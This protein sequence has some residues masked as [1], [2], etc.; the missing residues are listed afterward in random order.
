MKLYYA[1]PI[2]VSELEL[3]EIPDNEQRPQSDE[4][5]T[6]ECS[7]SSLPMVSINFNVKEGK[8]SHITV[9]NAKQHLFTEESTQSQEQTS[10]FTTV[11]KIS[12]F[13]SRLPGTSSLEEKST[14]KNVK[15]TRDIRKSPSNFKRKESSKVFKKYPS[16][17]KSPENETWDKECRQ[18]IVDLAENLSERLLAEIDRYK[19]RNVNIEKD[20]DTHRELDHHV[21]PYLTKLSEELSH[22]SKLTKELSADLDVAGSPTDGSSND[23]LVTKGID[24]ST[25]TCDV[26]N[27]RKPEAIQQQPKM[28]EHDEHD[29]SLSNLIVKDDRIISGLISSSDPSTDAESPGSISGWLDSRR[30][31]IESGYSRTA[32][33]DKSEDDNR[34]SISNIHYE[35]ASKLNSS[36]TRSHARLSIES[37]DMTDVSE[38]AVSVSSEDSM[39][40]REAMQTETSSGLSVESDF[41]DLD[42]S[43]D[44][45]KSTEY[46]SAAGGPASSTKQYAASMNYSV[47]QASL[48]RPG[49]SVES[50]EAGDFS[51]RT[52]SVSDY[53][54]QNTESRSVITQSS[55]S[56]ASWSDCSKD[57]RFA[58]RRTARCDGRSSSEETN[59]RAILTRQQ[60]ATQEPSEVKMTSTGTS[61]SGS[62]SQDSLTSESTGGSIMFHRYYHVFREGEL[63]A[64]IDEFVENLHIISSYYDHTNWCIIAEKVRVWTI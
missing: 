30:N 22:V 59:P 46:S 14:T 60:A 5:K 4:C 21:D 24:C 56:L 64:L 55:A 19:E 45:S 26:E 42:K 39:S 35:S 17:S 40:K 3:P 33:G 51:D 25:D 53:S 43:L 20:L 52:G 31:T 38:K 27:M 2:S 8:P 44:T 15:V 54:R 10:T 29:L 12:P 16:L 61:L 50:S 23:E 6:Q 9:S 62:T 48:L 63:D 7:I 37:T 28:E 1:S 13:C 34:T 11:K 57:I 49:E 18:Y 32:A 41:C 58:D 47:S 36:E